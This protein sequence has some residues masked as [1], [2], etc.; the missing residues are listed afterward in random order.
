M[1]IG[2]GL[3]KSNVLLAACQALE[4][5]CCIVT[6]SNVQG[7]YAKSLKAFLETQ[8]LDEVGIVVMPAGEAYKT[9]ETKQL[10]EDQLFEA[11][12]GRDTYLLALG[13][14]VVL[15]MAGF[16]AATF[17]RGVP[18]IYLPTTVLAMADA[19]LGGKTGVNTPYGKNLV[20]SFTQPQAIFADLDTLSSLP[21]VEYQQGWAEVIKHALIQSPEL[22]EQLSRNI[23]QIQQRDAH[24]L[25]DILKASQAIK[26]AIVE[27]DERDE[28]I[29]Q[30]LNFGHTV[31]HAV[32]LVSDYGI[33]HG[34]AVAM[35]MAA[36][37]RLAMEA[38]ILAKSDFHQIIM[39][40]K[41]YGF[42]T[43]LPMPLA[44]LYPAMQLD[45]KSKSSVPQFVALEGIGKPCASVNQYG[46][47]ALI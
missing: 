29:R 34:Q 45:K 24:V 32:E 6:D 19:C 8:G 7:L 44:D 10:I 11:G 36:E 23:D 21:D 25:S 26:Q 18:V 14:G 42:Q 2:S 37:S 16:V 40:L 41:Q 43:D 35:G 15:D 46:L 5:R 12:Y 9:R 27:Q 17:C 47:K 38:G 4:G 13:G 30:S 39:L 33:P 20:G 22:F 1:Q 31:G 3:L 28:G